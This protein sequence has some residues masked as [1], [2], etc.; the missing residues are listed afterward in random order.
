MTSSCFYRRY[1]K[2]AEM[3]LLMTTKNNR[4]FQFF[5]HHS[6]ELMDYDEIPDIKSIR[7]SDLNSYDNGLRPFLGLSEAS[8]YTGGTFTNCTE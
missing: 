2:I 3:L 8:C 5:T 7:I 6:G 1:Q 4:T